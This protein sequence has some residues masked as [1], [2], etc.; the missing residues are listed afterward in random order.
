MRDIAS[1]LDFKP[2]LTP[3]APITDNTPLVSRILDRIGYESAAFVVMTGQ[4][5]DADATFA[6]TVEHGDAANLSDATAVPADQL[7]G[8]LTGASFNFAADDTIRKIG[9]VGG[10][11]YV[12]VTI[13]PAANS[14][15]AFIAGLWVLG[16]ANL[17]PVA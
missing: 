4:L 15:N 13:T 16:T 14:G 7:N 1:R 11:R 12:R 8:T 3:A 5:V 10:K 9:Y 6:V 17:K 2:G